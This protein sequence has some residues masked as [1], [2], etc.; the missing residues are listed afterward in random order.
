VVFSLDVLDEDGNGVSSAE[1]T[2]TVGIAAELVNSEV[3]DDDDDD[4]DATTAFL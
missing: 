4:D 3:P 2:V 1:D